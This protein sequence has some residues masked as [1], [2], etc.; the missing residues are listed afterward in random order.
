MGIPSL[1]D[2]DFK[3]QLQQMRQTDNWTN[4]LYLARTY[5]FL[6]LVI[7]G[8]IWFDLYRQE[9][10]WSWLW[11]ML[12]FLP[13]IVMIGAGQHQLSGLAHEGVPQRTG[14]GLVLPVP[15]FFQHLPLPFAT[16]GPSSV[17][18]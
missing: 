17:R 15:H 8:C 4:F 7:G 13:A 16:S 12:L 11:S 2:A 1:T 18:E 10:G 5:L 14:L 3:A 9:Q 6:G